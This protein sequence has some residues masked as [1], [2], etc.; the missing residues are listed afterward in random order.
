MTTF[1]LVRHAHAHWTPDETRPLSAQGQEDAQRVARILGPKPISHIYA[2]PYRRARQTVEP[3]AE[4]LGL[5]IVELPALR[6]RQLAAGAVEDFAGAAEATWLDPSFCHPGGETNAVAQERG[7]RAVLGL[8][9]QQPT[10]HLVLA[11]HGTLLVL[12]LQHFD[13]SIGYAF[14][15]SLTF[16]DIYQLDLPQAGAPALN[17]LWPDLPPAKP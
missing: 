8:C 7:V 11:T 1:Y 13:P 4:R 15:Q 6:E 5:P 14:W 10:G 12:I 17:R 3:L 16:P 9:E 2:S